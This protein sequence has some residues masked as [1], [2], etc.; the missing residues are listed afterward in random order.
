M[1]LHYASFFFLNIFL[2]CQ[3]MTRTE[4]FY[5]LELKI[6]T[7]HTINTLS[8]TYSEFSRGIWNICWRLISWWNLSKFV[9]IEH[10]L[11]SLSVHYLY[12]KKRVLLRY[13]SRTWAEM[14]C[15]WSMCKNWSE[16]TAENDGIYRSFAVEFVKVCRYKTFWIRIFAR[17]AFLLFRCYSI[18]SKLCV[19]VT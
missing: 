1:P 14:T 16:N 8:I 19:L 9:V 11:G 6:Y 12:V 10:F 2:L 7:K 18:H 3:N 4:Y 13:F 17:R 15:A 5:I